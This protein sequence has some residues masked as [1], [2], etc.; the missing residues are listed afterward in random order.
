MCDVFM[1]VEVWSVFVGI[2]L[3][4][5]CVVCDSWLYSCVGER[6]VCVYVLF[7]MLCFMYYVVVLVVRCFCL[8]VDLHVLS[9]VRVLCFV[10]S[11]C[12]VC[13]R[14]CSSSMYIL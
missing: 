11:L 4:F 14:C 8:F 10:T 7:D 13:V 3:C 5:V 1:C 6:V 2:D 12:V 9:V